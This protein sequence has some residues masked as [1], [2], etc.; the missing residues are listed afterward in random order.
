MTVVYAVA[1]TTIPFMISFVVSDYESVRLDKLN[2]VIY[3]F[4]WIDILLNC[5]T[6]V[7][8]KKEMSVNLRQMDIFKYDIK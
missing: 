2:I 6:G 3:A 5:I 7:E 1:F 4:F 8:N